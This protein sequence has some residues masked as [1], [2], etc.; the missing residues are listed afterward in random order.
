M[1]TTEATS[2]AEQPE[3]QERTGAW[4]WRTWALVVVFF[5][6]ALAGSAVVGIPLRDPG[7]AFFLGK[8]GIAAFVFVVLAVVDGVWRAKPRTPRG[9]WLAITRRWTWRRLALAAAGIVAYYAVYASYR[10]LKSWDIFRG[11]YDHLLD[12]WDR[13]LLFGQSPAVLLHDLLG[14]HTAMYVL[15]FVYR[16]FTPVVTAVL[17][18]SLVFNRRI[19]DGF[20]MVVAGMWGWILG[21]ASYYLI[22][23]L[24]P[25]WYTPDEYAGLPRT[26]IQGMQADIVAKRELLLANHSADVVSGISAFASLHVAMTAIVW[27]MARYY[28]WRVLSWIIGL[29]L[30]LTV[31]ATLYL[32][33][34]YIADDVAGF[35]I[36]FSAVLLARKMIYP[37]GRPGGEL[38]DLARERRATSAS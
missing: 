28:G 3:R 23:S 34:H 18:G 8:L 13:A 11:P 29:F 5:A 26:G 30:A 10:N 35:A 6:I 27:L 9:S 37:H 33:W 24:G 7:N 19:R 12:A 21:T 36:A 25:F 22:P 15:S 2:R 1:S 32:G 17:I 38:R 16:S 14:E 20:V 4:F 31:V